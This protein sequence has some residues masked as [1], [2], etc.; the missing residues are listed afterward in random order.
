[1]FQPVFS[2]KAVAALEGFV[3]ELCEDLLDGLE[4]REEI[5][6]SVDF[7]EHIPVAVIAQ[8]VGVDASDGDKFRGFVHDVLESVDLEEEARF[9]KLGPLLSY[10]EERIVEHVAEPKDDL[11]SFL[12]DA[13]LDGEPLGME[14]VFG[15]I[16]LLIVAGIDTTW[17]AI[18]SSLWHL[19]R[20]R[21]QAQELRERPEKMA[22]AVEELLRAYS[23]VNMARLVKEDFEF[24]GCQMKK[25]DWV[26]LSF[27]AANRDPEVFVCPDEVDFDRI[28]NRHAAFGLGP[29]R[30]LGSN[31]ARMEIRVALEAFLGRYE[32]FELDSRHEVTWSQGQ[33]RGP[34]KLALLVKGRAEADRGGTAAR[35]ARR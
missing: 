2:P 4:G 13:E 34:R 26:L 3:R 14:H 5:D 33:V 30:C 35:T 16:A 22:F 29:H 28:G 8:M 10:I 9:E 27:P 20:S 15:S 24:Q 18:G 11:I 12:L 25:D 17:S 21:E 6:G 1:M 23:P 19:A 31:L 32:S 7:A